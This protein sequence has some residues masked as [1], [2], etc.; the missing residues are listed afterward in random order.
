[1]EITWGLT[2]NCSKCTVDLYN[3][4]TPKRH[5]RVPPKNNKMSNKT[6]SN[7]QPKHTGFT[8]HRILADICVTNWPQWWF[9]SC[10]QEQHDLVC[11][12]HSPPFD[13]Y[14]SCL[15]IKVSQ[16][17]DFVLILGDTW[18]SLQ[19]AEDLLVR[20]ETWVKEE[21]AKYPS[22]IFSKHSHNPRF[23]FNT[24]NTVINP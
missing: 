23:P 14:V 5:L 20:H 11:L 12:V 24:T 18:M 10:I 1:M 2:C 15:T 6:N 8:D 4:R 16:E 17:H 19:L 3:A 22:G 7:L 13:R 21:R 9:S